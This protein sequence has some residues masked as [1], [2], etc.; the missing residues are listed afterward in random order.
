MNL[1]ISGD[2]FILSIEYLKTHKCDN[3][4]NHS[5]NSSKSLL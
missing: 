1:F 2:I 4:T 3:F 5:G